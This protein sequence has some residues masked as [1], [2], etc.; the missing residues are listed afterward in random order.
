MNLWYE[1]VRLTTVGVGVGF[2]DTHDDG[3]S[4]MTPHDGPI[5]VVE[6]HESRLS[7]VGS[8]KKHLTDPTVQWRDPVGCTL[9]TKQLYLRMS[10]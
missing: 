1:R 8:R 2:D 7:V 9:L 6:P 4:H 10:G 3:M 5:K